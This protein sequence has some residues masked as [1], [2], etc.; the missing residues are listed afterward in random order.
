[1][2]SQ[3]EIKEIKKVLMNG[4]CIF[5]VKG[6]DT[7]QEISEGVYGYGLQH[8]KVSKNSNY[9]SE[10]NSIGVGGQMNISKFT[11]NTIHLFTYSILHNQ[12]KGKI[13]LQDV[14]ILEVL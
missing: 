1:M 3:K 7:Y 2:K 6:I 14:T 11:K 9:I 5:T 8:L 13:N 10:V 12:V 4:N